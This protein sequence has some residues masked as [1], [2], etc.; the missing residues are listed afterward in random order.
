MGR[1]QAASVAL[2][3]AWLCATLFMWFLAGASFS[4]VERILRTPT[5]QFADAARPAGEGRTRVLLRY[6]ASE[7]N[8]AC[9]RAYGWGKMALGAVLLALLLGQKP[10]DVTALALVGTML[11]LVVVLTLILTPQMVRLGRDLDFVPRQ[12]P[13]PEMAR[14]RTLHA[15]FTGLDGV[16]LLAG[17]GLL[18]RWVMAR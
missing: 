17:L 7:I 4:A 12:P 3:G 15:A 14:F 18:A 9:F 8:R 2:L 13:P 10:R 5:P 6:L 11:G 1:L 16:K